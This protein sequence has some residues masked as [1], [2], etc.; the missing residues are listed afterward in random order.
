MK[1]KN[2]AADKIRKEEVTENLKC[3]LTEEEIRQAGETTAKLIQD[4]GQLE[5]DK[6]SVMAGFKAKIDACEAGIID[7][8]NK[9]RDKYEYRDVLCEK[10]HNFTDYTIRVVR[11]DTGMTVEN[12]K[13][14]L[15]EKQKESLFD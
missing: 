7:N 13:M 12:R 10:Q 11:S 3:M 2:S 6:K 9:V 8:S 1:D 5:K 4:R 15:T 14:N